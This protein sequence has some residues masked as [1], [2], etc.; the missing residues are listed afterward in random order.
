MSFEN[1]PDQLNTA[2]KPA[3]KAP[4]KA[5]GRKSLSHRAGSAM[6]W[7]VV[8]LPLKALLG[9]FVSVVLVKTFQ[10]N[11]YA[12]LAIV[13][14]L[15]TT[16]GLYSDL[17][18]ERA[19]PRFV[20]EVELTQGQNGLKRFIMRL[21][22]IKLAVLAVLIVF[23]TIFANSAITLFQLGSLGR[24]YLALISSLLVLGAI[25][26]VC[27]AILYSFFKQ[28]VTNLLDVVVTILNPLLTILFV[29]LG[30]GVIGVMLA[31]LLTTIISV[32]IAAWQ[33][34]VAARESGRERESH[35]A[36]SK[37]KPILAAQPEPPGSAGDSLPLLENSSEIEIEK[38]QA[39]EINA[40]AYKIMRWDT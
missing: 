5:K 4:T 35:K 37:V 26:D 27:T 31:L 29:W 17:G 18:I 11:A 12:S 38:L 13:T 34:L 36:I 6:F 30:W 16:L 33:A 9:V 19:L 3:P 39:R 32:G 25:Y 21:T 28:K 22:L 23:F 20:G 2:P 10:L 14:S 24:L 7:N 15:Q 1:K 40:K 8:F